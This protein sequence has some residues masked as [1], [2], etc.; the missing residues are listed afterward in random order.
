[1]SAESRRGPWIRAASEFVV[2]VVG[3]LVALTFDQW[4]ADRQDRATELGYLTGLASDL[5]DDVTVYSEILIPL[6]DRAALALPEVWAVATGAVPFPRDTL[7]LVRTVVSS[8][9]AIFSFPIRGATY[10]ELVATGNLRLIQSAN[11][12]SAV[13]EYYGLKRLAEVRSQAA[14]SEYGPLVRGYVPL[15][16]GS[17]MPDSV[18]REYGGSELAEAVRSAEFRRALNRHTAYVR[19]TAQ[20]LEAIQVDA[21]ALFREVEAEIERLR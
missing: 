10:D 17:E 12:R 19:A 2:I 8:R 6:I 21:A 16:L 5:R 9:G 11:L 1:M 13:V 15:A 18:L 20:E 3:V 7:G 4:N 14:S